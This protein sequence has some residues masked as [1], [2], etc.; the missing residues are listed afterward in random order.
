MDSH[1]NSDKDSAVRQGYLIV[2]LSLILQAGCKTTKLG[3]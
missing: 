3:S 1:A 2:E